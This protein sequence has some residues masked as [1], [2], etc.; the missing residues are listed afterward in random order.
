MK[1]QDLLTFIAAIAD[2]IL[3]E[4]QKPEPE[5][6]RLYEIAGMIGKINHEIK[7]TNYEEL[8][9]TPD[10]QPLV[11]GCTD[12]NAANYDPLANQNDGSCAYYV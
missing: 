5:D 1:K 7:V 3:T 10:S 11:W 4:I 9:M 8:I 2:D 12:P 6:K